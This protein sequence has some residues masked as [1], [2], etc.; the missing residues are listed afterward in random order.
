VIAGSACVLSVD[1]PTGCSRRAT[2]SARQ[3]RRSRLSW[4]ARVTDSGRPPHV[5]PRCG[6][7]EVEGDAESRGS[8]RFY[9]ELRRPGRHAPRS[10][11]RP[12]ARGRSRPTTAARTGSAD[13]PSS[14]LTRSPRRR[15]VAQRRRR[16]LPA[17]AERVPVRATRPGRGPRS[18]T[19]GG[20]PR[21]PDAVGTPGRRGAEAVRRRHLQA[22]VRRPV[23][24]QPTA[25][26]WNGELRRPLQGAGLPQQAARRWNPAPEWVISN[27]P[28][29]PAQVSQAH[30]V[31]VQGIRATRP[32]EAGSQRAYLLPWGRALHRQT[33]TC[34]RRVTTRCESVRICR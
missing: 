24:R 20:G 14:P 4:S 16:W 26:V 10:R 12:T 22:G 13:G 25:V 6:L 7:P 28:A 27:R 15:R 32:P 17:R 29:H 11:S 31:A 30:F 34:R 21:R 1:R 19:R 2:S 3:R 18:R 8:G 9:R 33:R 23:P 5:V